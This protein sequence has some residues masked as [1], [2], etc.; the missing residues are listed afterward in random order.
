MCTEAEELIEPTMGNLL[1]LLPFHVVDPKA[2]AVGYYHKGQGSLCVYS[3]SEKK[4]KLKG[5]DE[6]FY[7]SM[8]KCFENIQ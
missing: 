2:Q 8:Q 5:E 1:L 6:D 3:T 4:R 7:E